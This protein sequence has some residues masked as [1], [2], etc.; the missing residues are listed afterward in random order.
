MDTNTPK[1]YVNTAGISESDR[2]NGL[3]KFIKTNKLSLPH[4]K[5]RITH[6]F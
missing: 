6:I 5:K 4:I 1:W 3:E 2:K